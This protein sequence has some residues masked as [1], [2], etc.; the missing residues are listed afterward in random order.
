MNFKEIVSEWQRQFPVLLP[1]TPPTLFAKADIVLIGLRLD[2]VMSDSYRVFLEILP[3][4]VEEDKIHIPLLEDE[5][6]NERGLQ[7]FIDRK[8]HDPTLADYV[9]KQRE[10]GVTVI[11]AN[12]LELE[13]SKRRAIIEKAFECAHRRFDAVL[14]ENVRLSDLFRLI[15][16][17]PVRGAKH[18]PLLLHGILELKLA[19]ATYCGDEAF[20]GKVRKDIEK[21]TG[22]WNKEAFLRNFHMSVEEWKTALYRK[23]ED[24]EVFLKQVDRNKDSEKI[25]RLNSIQIQN[26]VEYRQSLFQRLK[27][28]FLRNQ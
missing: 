8:F 2:K 21:E 20:A 26:D 27:D 25:A 9:E 6:L 18:N 16:S 10:R 23:M 17:T 22:Y 12:K 7:I 24:R 14:Q 4:W 28:L 13:K 5:L 19:L 1:Y 3:L 15:D 11:D